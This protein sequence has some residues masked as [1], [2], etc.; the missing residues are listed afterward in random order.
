MSEGDTVMDVLSMDARFMGKVSCSFG[1]CKSGSNAWGLGFG[2]W[3]F[4][5]EPRKL[6]NKENGKQGYWE[7]RIL[8]NEEIGKRGYWETRILG[9]EEIVARDMRRDRLKFEIKA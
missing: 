5:W 8:G 9:N 4:W 3:G 2:V 6:G 7:T 1:A